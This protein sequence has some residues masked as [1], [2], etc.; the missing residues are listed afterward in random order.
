[1]EVRYAR[2][3]VWFGLALGLTGQGW[4]LALLVND[5]PAPAL[6]LELGARIAGVHLAGCLLVAAGLSRALPGGTRGRAWLL[7]VPSLLFGSVLATL[8]WVAVL[9]AAARSRAPA[10]PQSVRGTAEPELPLRTDLGPVRSV[11]QGS[12]FG[13]L[14]F[15]RDPSVR[16]RAVMA[17]RRLPGPGVVALLK[18]ALRDP[19]EDVRLLG[20]AI[21]ERRQGAIYRRIQDA[22][23]ALERAPDQPGPHLELAQQYWELVYQGLV[24]GDLQSYLLAKARTHLERAA[25][26][27]PRN[28]SL[29]LLLGRIQLRQ[30]DYADA[31]LSLKQAR[32]LGMPTRVVNPHAAELAF[33]ERRFPE[34]R[35]LLRPMA[36]KRR[37]PILSRLV[38]YWQ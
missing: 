9:A 28:P 5:V 3:T 6:A 12:L 16:L 30:Q 2:V 32:A 34:V 38:E 11:G 23:G 14:R 33:A 36:E 4:A 1:L 35:R 17:A 8:G 25:K 10:P 13:R 19:V 7:L 18:L 27:D 37:G 15:A 24:G 20:Y 26:A 22:L 21:L 31:A 29:Q